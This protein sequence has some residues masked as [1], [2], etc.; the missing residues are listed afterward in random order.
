MRPRWPR[1]KTIVYVVDGAARV[2]GVEA[3]L[4]KWDTDDRGS[5]GVLV[6][7]RPTELQIAKRRPPPHVRGKIREFVSL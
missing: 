1:L 6:T 2:R 4:S 7:K 5:A 3:E